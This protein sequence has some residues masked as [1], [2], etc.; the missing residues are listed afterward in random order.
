LFISAVV[1]IRL[2]PLGISG[3][4]FKGRL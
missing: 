3:K 1:L 2:L 4:F